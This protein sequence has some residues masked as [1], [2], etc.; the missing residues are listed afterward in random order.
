MV[1][2]GTIGRLSISMPSKSSKITDTLSLGAPE[3]C[4]KGKL[5]NPPHTLIKLTGIDTDT[6]P[7]VWVRYHWVSPIF[8][9]LA[10]PVPRSTGRSPSPNSP[11]TKSEAETLKMGSPEAWYFWAFWIYCIHVAPNHPKSS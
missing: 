7:L 11:G 2:F 4:V 5:Q 10:G 8:G 6:K 3:G 1:G 9:D